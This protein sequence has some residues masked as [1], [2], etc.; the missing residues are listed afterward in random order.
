[1]EEDLKFSST[2]LTVDPQVVVACTL[3]TGTPKYVP[4]NIDSAPLNCE[5]SGSLLGCKLLISQL[6][7]I[8]LPSAFSERCV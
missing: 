6:L 8:C 7:L 5:A 2:V 3:A 4:D 1:V